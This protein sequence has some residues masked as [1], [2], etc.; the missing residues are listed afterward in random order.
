MKI[1]TVE[2]MRQIEADADAGGHSYAD[3]MEQA[4]TAIALAIA[5]RRTVR[6]QRILLLI[7]PGNNGG[8]GLVAARHL[9]KM[10]ASVACYLL[11]P[12]D[13]AKDENLRLVQE[14]AV[15]IVSADK[16][17]DWRKLRHLLQKTHIL[18]DA[19]LGTGTRLPIKGRMAELLGAVGRYLAT[20]SRSLTRSPLTSLAVPTPV[21]GN[22][23]FVVAVDGPSG[24]DFDSGAIDPLA[25]PAAVTVTFAYPKRGHFGGGPLGEL[26]VADIGTDP[27]LAADVSLQVITPEAVR[28]WLPP[29]PVDAH[30][31]TF[32]RTLIVAGST[33]Y[34]GAAYLAGAAAARAGA[35]LITMAIPATIHVPVASQ[36]AEATYLLLPHALGVIASGAVQV[37][38]PE[39][40]KCDALL[41]G[42][43]LGQE[44]ETATFLQGLLSGGS[45]RRPLGFAGSKTEGE[46]PFE[47]PPLVID[48]DGLNLLSDMEDWPTRLPSNSILTPHPGE[49]AQLMACT[50][51]DVQGDRIATAQSQATAWGHVIVLKGAHTVVAAPD[52]STVIAPFANPGL[53]TGG[54]GD[55]L[56]GII[57]A[58]RTQGMGPFESAAAGVYLHGLAGELARTEKGTAGM[59]AHDVLECLPAAWQHVGGS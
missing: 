31:G 47:I 27:K 12:R 32:G 42:P 6:N 1:V 38:A 34:T 9:A 48:A 2:E 51:Q 46:T 52:G 15:A 57:A 53:A 19:L 30:K 40:A 35:G 44:P 49:M 20:G 11:K 50:I 45:E 7:G 41:I 3:M 17:K 43:G 28:E 21:D 18:V 58:L 39:L 24:L 25:I 37:L 54:T 36:L 26:V 10:G 59:V 29:R 22:I 23:P 13:P 4:G 33:N 14:L 55:V 5:A 56:A 8:D 16:D